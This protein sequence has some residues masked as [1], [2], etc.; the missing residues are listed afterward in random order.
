MAQHDERSALGHVV[1]NLHASLL[2]S[3]RLLLDTDYNDLKLRLSPAYYSQERALMKSGRHPEEE[4]LRFLGGCRG[5]NIVFVDIGA[6]T[7]YYSLHAA[8]YSHPDSHIIA[9]EPDPRNSLKLA[10]QIHANG[11]DKAIERLECAIGAHQGTMELYVP[12]ERDFGQNSLV[13]AKAGMRHPQAIEISVQTLFDVVN[14]LQLKRIDYLKID[15]EGYED[16]ALHPF[17]AQAPSALWPKRVLME[18][19]INKSWARNILT[20]MTSNGYSVVH[21]SSDNVWM[22]LDD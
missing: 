6:N 7:G 16:K 9:I 20:E 8:R 5:Q 3:P 12:D 1:K 13:P 19:K 10:F 18:S 11:F 17:Y 14:Q 2:K 21:E 22:V 4:D 15:V